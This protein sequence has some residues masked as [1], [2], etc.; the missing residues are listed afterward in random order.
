MTTRLHD[1]VNNLPAPN[2]DTAAQATERATQNVR[3]PGALARLDALAAH[4]AGWQGT[5]SPAVSNPATLVFAGDHG[6]AAAG[7]S[8]FPAD[9]T[10][11]MLAAVQQEVATISVMAN[12]IG[13]S[14][15]VFDVGVG[16]PTGDIRTEDALTVDRFNEICDVAVDAVNAAADRGADLVVLG[17]LGIGNT[18]AAAAVA[19]AIAG[20]DASSWVGRGTGVDDEGFARKTAAVDAA[21]SRVRADGDTDPIHL[22]RRVGGSELVAMAA[23]C[24]QARQRSIPVV[25]DGY[26][27]TSAIAALHGATPGALD[28]CILGHLSAEPGHTRLVEFIGGDTTMWKP[29]LDLD[30]RLGEGSGAL[31]AVPLVKMACDIVVK[32]PTFA[33]WFGE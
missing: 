8:A 9:V 17:E 19:A 26:I 11:A 33:E 10:A 3:P 31:A 2:S 5:A 16:T 30:F 20:G 6:V 28:H 18:T 27:A 15:E 32:V 4:M 21:L 25:V 7:V 12:A 24:A 29:L 14:C 22:L 13:A 1:L 23:A